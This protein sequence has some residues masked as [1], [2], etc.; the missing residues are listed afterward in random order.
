MST[1]VISSR[2][3]GEVQQPQ[4]KIGDN[5]RFFNAMSLWFCQSVK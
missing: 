4:A 5:R 1:I 2:G 3:L